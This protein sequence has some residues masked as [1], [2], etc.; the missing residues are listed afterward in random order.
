[1]KIKI[2]NRNLTYTYNKQFEESLNHTEYEKQMKKSL[3][4]TKSHWTTSYD[5][6]WNESTL[7]GLITKPKI[8]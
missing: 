4:E 1:L 5:K 7:G 6:K 3:N 8:E 2:V